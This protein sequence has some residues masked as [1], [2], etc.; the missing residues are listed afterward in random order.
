MGYGTTSHGTLIATAAGAAAVRQGGDCRVRAD[1]S[2][3]Y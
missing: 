2:G 3:P 1:E